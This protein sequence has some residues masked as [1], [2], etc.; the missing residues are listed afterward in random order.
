MQF[1]VG[2]RYCTHM[3]CTVHTV[4]S[5]CERLM[6][7]SEWVRVKLYFHPPSVA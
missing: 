1:A 5:R 6:E 3:T 2:D 7:A 4:R